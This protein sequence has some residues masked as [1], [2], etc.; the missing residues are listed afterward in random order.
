MLENV[1]THINSNED[2]IQGDLNAVLKN[3]ANATLEEV[4][5]LSNIDIETPPTEDDDQSKINDEGI[6]P[7][8][9]NQVP[10]LYRSTRIRRIPA[11]YKD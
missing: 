7:P 10:N 2:N 6:I 11:R 9:V 1:C 8:N 4:D 5:N 3:N